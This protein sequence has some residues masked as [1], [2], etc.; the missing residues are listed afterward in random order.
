MKI[1]TKLL[2]LFLSIATY[3]QNGINYK[4]IVKDDLGNVVANTTIDVQFS[5]LQGVAQTNVYQETHSPTTDSNGVI[6]VNIG[7]GVPSSGDFLTIDWDSDEHFLNVQ[8]DTGSGLADMGTTAFRAV[9]YAIQSKFTSNLTQSNDV[10][11]FVQSTIRNEPMDL[12]VNIPVSESGLYY[13]GFAV[14]YGGLQGG[15]TSNPYDLGIEAN[16]YKNVN[17]QKFSILLDIDVPY[18]YNDGSLFYQRWMSFSKLNNFKVDYLSEGDIITLE[19][20]VQSLSNPLPNSQYQLSQ[21]KVI[22][23]K[24]TD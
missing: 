18:F 15:I 12:G 3:A 5:I 4:A 2:L 20:E 19:V 11:S 14:D 22:L 23:I 24:L 7:E 6:F 1:I 10:G 13:I 21:A 9:P 8:I 17:G 16:L